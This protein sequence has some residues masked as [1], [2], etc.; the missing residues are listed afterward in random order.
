MPIPILPFHL[1]SLVFVAWN[2][3]SADKL[4]FA[5]FRGAL[6]TVDADRIRTYHNRMWI[7]LLLMIITGMLLFLPQRETLLQ[8]PA[9]FVKMF[10]V[11]L[12][13]INGFVI[14]ELSRVVS[15]KPYSSLTKKE[16]IP[17]LLSGGV[18][19][20]GWLGAVILAFF[21]LD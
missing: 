8:T 5:W 6:Q 15:K 10:F 13:V 1:L 9:F 4:V 12:L 14:G 18:S 7:G 17:L 20:V 16:K 19:L 21:L 3:F 2:M 11:G